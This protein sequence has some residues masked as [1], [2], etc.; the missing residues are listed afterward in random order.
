M[1]PVS[2]DAI[3]LRHYDWSET[4][5][6]VVLLT[7]T[8]GLV[9][10]LAKGARRAKSS[11]SG[12]VE[13]LARADIQLYVRTDKDLDLLG[14]WDLTDPHLRLRKSLETLNAGL[15]AV[16]L[17]ANLLDVHDPHSATFDALVRTLTDL[18]GDAPT[19]GPILGFQLELLRDVGLAP[20]LDTG[21][22]DAE[23]L[24]FDPDAGGLIPDPGASPGGP[25][26]DHPLDPGPPPWRV[27]RRTVE[28]LREPESAD[29]VSVV[30]AARLLNA[31]IATRIGRMPV[32]AGPWFA[33]LTDD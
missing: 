32:A 24:A 12:G 4:S 6:T 17:V 22:S 29:P 16:D 13:L 19:A 8:H 1:P 11:F 23:T 7:R 2:D 3:C 18:G 25:R 21:G 20:T 27:R 31:W 10:A 33:L 30:R 14:V 28:A 9:R 26:S 5:Q 15:Y